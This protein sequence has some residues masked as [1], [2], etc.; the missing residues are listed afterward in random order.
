MLFGLNKRPPK[1][2]EVT[3]PV[4]GP[5]GE[6]GEEPTLKEMLADPMIQQLA[7][8]DKIQPG[9]LSDNVEMMRRKLRQKK[10][11]H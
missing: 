2:E 9:E 1:K 10:T 6:G 11:K 8:S 7:R 3:L 5:Y 4:V